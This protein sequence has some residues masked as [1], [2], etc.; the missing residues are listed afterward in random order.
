VLP[1]SGTE[2][3]LTLQMYAGSV[4]YNVYQTENFTFA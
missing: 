2:Y 3:T 4:A 1:A